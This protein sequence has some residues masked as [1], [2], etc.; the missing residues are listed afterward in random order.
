MARATS[1]GRRAE[2]GARRERD[3]S[4][5]SSRPGAARRDQAKAGGQPTNA[6]MARDEF[7]TARPQTRPSRRPARQ[8]AS[9]DPGRAHARGSLADP[10]RCAASAGRSQRETGDER[11]QEVRRRPG[12]GH[13]GH[14]RRADRGQERPRPRRRSGPRPRGR[15]GPTSATRSSR[16]ERLVEP[17]DRGGPRPGAARGQQVRVEGAVVGLVPEG[18]RPA[19]RCRM[20]RAISKR[21]RV[22]VGDRQGEGR[23]GAAGRGPGEHDG[24][25]EGPT[26]TLRRGERTVMRAAAVCPKPSLAVEVHDPLTWPA[27]LS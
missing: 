27:L 14:V 3:A 25:A 10:R 17:E 13:Q 22:V 1:S 18:R 6:G 5:R 9:V 16:A 12:G 20:W 11:H 2:G 7:Q 4:P 15:A 24:Q 23:R 8:A 26:S 19:R 21:D